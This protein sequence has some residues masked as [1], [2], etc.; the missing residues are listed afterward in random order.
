MSYIIR[1]ELETG[2]NILD[3]YAIQLQ[4]HSVLD[5]PLSKEASEVL[6]DDAKK[7]AGGFK[8]A[9]VTI[10]G[11][12]DAVNAGMDATSEHSLVDGMNYHFDINL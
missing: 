3:S 9:L 1:E 10:L 12:L 4:L 8:E 6:I 2:I 5:E 11:M 7:L